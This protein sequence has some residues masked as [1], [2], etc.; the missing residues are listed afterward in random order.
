MSLLG[1][2]FASS[3]LLTTL[4]GFKLYSRLWMGAREKNL[5]SF[6]NSFFEMSCKIR[7]IPCLLAVAQTL[8]TSWKSLSQ[9]LCHFLL[10]A[11]LFSQLFFSWKNILSSKSTIVHFSDKS[12]LLY[13]SSVPVIVKPTPLT[14]NFPEHPDMSLLPS[15]ATPGLFPGS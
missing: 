15:P 13:L 14:N 7:P 8:V 4:K 3:P 2:T 11:S 10:L 5:V 6:I 1:S 12:K 9:C